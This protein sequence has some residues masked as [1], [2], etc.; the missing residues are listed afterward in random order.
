MKGESDRARITVPPAVA[1]GRWW[2]N[3]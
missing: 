1:W 2:F 3:S